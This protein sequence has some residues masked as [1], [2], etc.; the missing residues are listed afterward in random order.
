M[1]GPAVLVVDDEPVLLQVLA[2]TLRA[3]GFDATTCTDGAAAAELIATRPFAVVVSDIDMP[4]LGGVELLQLLREREIDVPV[5]L[6]TGSPTLETAI[7]AVE[8]G[9][10]KYLMKPIAP[11]ELTDVVGRAVRARLTSSVLRR[12]PP[13]DHAG[14]ASRADVS[15]GA[16]LGGRYRLARPLGEGGMSQVWEAVHVHTERAVAVKVLHAGLNAKPEMRNRL[17]REAR[18][19]GALAHPH[20]V[21]VVDLFELQDGTPVLVMERMRG[22]TLSQHFAALGALGVEAAADLLL[23]VVSA[24]GTAHSRGV[25]HRD[26]KPDNVFLAE[27]GGRSV[28]KV[29]DFGIAKLL[30]LE[31]EEA[32]IRTAT[33]AMLGTPG[34]MAPEQAFGERDVDV[35]ADVW[36]IG[37]MLYEAIAGVRPIEA[38][39]VGQ[40]VKVLMVDGIVPLARRCPQL[41]PGVG[42]LV[43][44]M[45]TRERDERPADLRV[46]YT[47]LSRYARVSAPPFGAPSLSVPPPRDVAIA[48]NDDTFVH[49]RTEQSR[50]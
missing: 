40:M 23:P 12:G 8:H 4:Q 30:S 7:R 42:A 27:E 5:V 20:V 47:E 46:L 44:R 11:E 21:D 6:M 18:V 29:L 26:L 28:V 35:R 19:A 33:G 31:P 13:S 49:A 34:Y 37:V 39:S 25:V 36:A 38:N 16:V 17:L 24:V 10:F 32:T 50:K 45:L 43:D 15:A 3:G 1:S 2:R 48:S 14:P 22:R 41:P 9:A